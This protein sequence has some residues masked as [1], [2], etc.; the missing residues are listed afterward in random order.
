MD[1]LPDH[2]PT[3]AWYLRLDIVKLRRSQREMNEWLRGKTMTD[4][5][6]SM[7]LRSLM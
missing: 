3:A 2:I 7:R 1:N 6:L 5:V 4:G